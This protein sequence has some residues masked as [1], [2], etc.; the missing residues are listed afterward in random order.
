[1]CFQQFL[2][3]LS[4]KKNETLPRCLDHHTC[5]ESSF[6]SKGYQNIQDEN[7]SKVW[8]MDGSNKEVK[9]WTV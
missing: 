4:G 9:E 1:M 3:R 2:C 8:L 5:L 7:L 6:I